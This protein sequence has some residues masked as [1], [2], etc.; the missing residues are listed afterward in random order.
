MRPSVR[1]IFMLL[2]DEKIVTEEE[3]ESR[4]IEMKKRKENGKIENN[5]KSQSWATD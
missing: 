4:K 3:L 2:F 1:P 5:E